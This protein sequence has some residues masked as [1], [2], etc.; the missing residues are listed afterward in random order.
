MTDAIL[1]YDFDAWFD[2]TFHKVTGFTYRRGDP[3]RML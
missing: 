1:L 2:Q 3:L